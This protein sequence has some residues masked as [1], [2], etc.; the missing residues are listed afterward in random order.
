[1]ESRPKN[2][3]FGRADTDW[4]MAIS[5][6]G[7]SCEVRRPTLMVYEAAYLL[8]E[9]E[10]ATRNRVRRGERLTRLGLSDEQVVGNGALP[11]CGGTGR[12][13][14]RPAILGLLPEIADNPMASEL[15]RSVVAGRFRVP[16]AVSPKALPPCLDQR[17]HRL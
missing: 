16:K 6:A 14:I 17:I 12:R 10:Q 1:M 3:V 4:V 5:I 7:R 15:L 11:N 2:S 8:Q 9:P 13:Q